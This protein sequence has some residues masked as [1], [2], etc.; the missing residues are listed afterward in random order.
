MNSTANGVYVFLLPKC[1]LVLHIRVCWKSKCSTPSR[2]SPSRLLT[3]SGSVEVRILDYQKVS[4]FNY[5]LVLL[6]FCPPTESIRLLDRFFDIVTKGLAHNIEEEETQGDVVEETDNQDGLESEFEKP[7]PKTNASVKITTVKH[8][9]VMLASLPSGLSIAL[10]CSR[11]TALFEV[12]S[13]PSVQSALLQTF[14]D[15]LIRDGPII[16]APDVDIIFGQLER[17]GLR[18]C[19]LDGKTSLT[20]EGWSQEKL[21]V[22]DPITLLLLVVLGISRTQ[23][24]ASF[25][26]RYINIVEKM[27]ATQTKNSKRWMMEYMQRNAASEEELKMMEGYPFGPLLNLRSHLGDFVRT[28]R[29][30]ISSGLYTHQAY[31]RPTDYVPSC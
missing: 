19:G 7:R 22:I 8:L 30:E 27:Y 16:A 3:G 12:T 21:P 10:V 6:R 23:V 13:H 1:F 24:P 26:K 28:W 9:V 25:A 4:R 5:L 15:L 18:V 11:L 2:T 29:K 31:L 17:I 20:E 14:I